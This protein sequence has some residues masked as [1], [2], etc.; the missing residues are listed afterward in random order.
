MDGRGLREGISQGLS[1]GISQGIEVALRLKF[2]ASALRLMPEIRAIDDRDKL[3]AILNA[4]ETA[5]SPDDLRRSGPAEPEILVSHA[6][7]KRPLR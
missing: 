2:G 1:Q 6:E 4:V 7:P 5:A 3:E